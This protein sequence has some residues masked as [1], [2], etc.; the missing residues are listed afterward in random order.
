MLRNFSLTWSVIDLWAIGALIVVFGFPAI[1]TSY[2]LSQTRSDSLG[3]F[4]HHLGLNTARPFGGDRT[5]VAR[6]DIVKAMTTSVDLT[7]TAD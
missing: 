7:P 6:Y 4:A 5:G 1:A 2:I 3:R